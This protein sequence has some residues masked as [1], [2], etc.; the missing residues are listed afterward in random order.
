MREF[1]LVPLP[2]DMQGPD[3]PDTAVA[4]DR[5]P[6]VV[7]RH[8]DCGRVLHDPEVSRRHCRFSYR[9]GTAWVEDL[10]SRN[11]TRLNGKLLTE[12]RPLAEGDRLD[13]AGLPFLCLSRLPD[14]AADP[15]GEIPPAAL[16]LCDHSYLSKAFP[17]H[18]PPGQVGR[19]FRPWPF[20]SRC[21]MPHAALPRRPENHQPT[22]LLVEDDENIRFALT[23]VL[24]WEGYM[25]LTAATG[26]DAVGMLRD[27]SEP[28]DV[29]LLDVGLPDVSGVDLCSRLRQLRPELPVV[30]CSGEADP[31]EVARLLELGVRRYFQKPVEPD[32]LLATV[33]AALR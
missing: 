2:T 23:R 14:K 8:P 9:D 3:D 31:Q 4:I 33:E 27:V 7:G 5:F 18:L 19:V 30:V 25:V 6:C 12:A 15:F 24:V 32:E 28:I 10:G 16:L 17:P 11:G 21:P 13:L 20:A 1:Y 26:H 22:V 29:V